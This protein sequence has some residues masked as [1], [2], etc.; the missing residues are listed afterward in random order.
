MMT[1]NKEI[2]LFLSKFVRDYIFHFNMLERNIA[3]SLRHIR[4]QDSGSISIE[5]LLAMP[6][7]KK[8]SKLEK[9]ISEQ[10]L[11]TNICEWLEAID[12]CRTMRNR[13]VH[14]NWEVVWHLDKPIR[15]DA[16]QIKSGDQ[17]IVEGNYTIES[18]SEELIE[19]KK[20]A[21]DFSKLRSKYE[22]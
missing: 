21:E 15:F 6:F 9:V 22:N 3:Y 11:N 16:C 19:L 2:E 8:I 10:S 7:C 4:K 12:H 18:L 14:G 5:S 20:V 17:S 13:L 1:S